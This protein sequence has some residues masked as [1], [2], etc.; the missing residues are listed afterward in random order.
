MAHLERAALAVW[1]LLV[2]VA[3]DDQEVVDLGQRRDILALSLR[4]RT[5]PSISSVSSRD[6]GGTASG[7]TSQWSKRL[8]ARR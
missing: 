2:R 5:V 8:A 3:G 7:R 1:V 4:A 6:S